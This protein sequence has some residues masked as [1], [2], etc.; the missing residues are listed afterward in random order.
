MTIPNERKDQG[1]FF[2]RGAGTEGAAGYQHRGT[3]KWVLPRVWHQHTPGK[4][5]GAV[6]KSRPVEVW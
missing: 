4:Y 2:G 6:E 5:G 3:G 1:A